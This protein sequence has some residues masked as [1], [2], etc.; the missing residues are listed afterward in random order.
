MRRVVCSMVA[1]GLLAGCDPTGALIP[2]DLDTI[3]QALG[4]PNGEL[5]TT[6]ARGLAYTIYNL[7]TV[8]QAV[9]V[10]AEALPGIDRSPLFEADAPDL[11]GCIKDV[12][13]GFEVDFPCLGLVAGKLKLEAMSELANDNGTYQLSLT[14]AS[15]SEGLYAEGSFQMRVEGIA[16]PVAVE[17]TTLAPVARLNGMPRFFETVEQAGIVIDNSRGNEALY[18]V[19]SVLDAT[20]VVQVDETQST[21]TALLF[22]VQDV[23]NLWTCTSKLDGNTITSS[24]CRTPVGQGDFAE[25]RF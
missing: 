4:A 20:F 6:D 23:K 7:R 2:M 3:E 15:L 1:A 14:R 9:E 25:L 12:P 8:L 24:E 19:A 17:K 21:D 18:Y 10:A 11:T 13:R 22:R 16:N 5:E